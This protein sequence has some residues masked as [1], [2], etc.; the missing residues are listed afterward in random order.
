MIGSSQ[1]RKVV[2]ASVVSLV[3]SGSVAHTAIGSS[4]NDA[5]LE[6]AGKGFSMV[7]G[8]E[9]STPRV[10]PENGNPATVDRP[11]FPD[12]PDAIQER[13]GDWGVECKSV[14]RAMSCS[15][16]QIHYNPSKGLLLFSI[17]IFPSREGQ[18]N[19]QITMPFG[20]ELSE[21]IRLQ[22]DNQP[23]GPKA[24]FATCLQQGCLV[25]IKISN[26]LL[27]MIRNAEN[28]RI[29]STAYGADEHPAI[30]VSLSGFSAALDR[31]K[32]LNQ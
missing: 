4:V 11:A 23:A 3:L 12:G 19:I 2:S 10:L 9:G 27:E 7:E 25:G 15:M 16:S 22:L 8:E 32:R 6:T 26:E 21:G 30:N 29:V 24:N 13:Y 20:L 5:G 31:L 18:T 17:E 1:I 28:L 14:D